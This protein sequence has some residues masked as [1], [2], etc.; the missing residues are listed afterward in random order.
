MGSFALSLG[1][2]IASALEL[3]RGAPIGRFL[4]AET[5]NGFGEGRPHAPAVLCTRIPPRSSVQTMREA[6][7]VPGFEARGVV[8]KI[9]DG[10][11][12]GVGG[13]GVLF[14]RVGAPAF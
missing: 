13:L 4:I 11:E 8:E 9:G 1:A 5:A 6:L 7:T 3:P 14:V 10:Q 2:S 12:G